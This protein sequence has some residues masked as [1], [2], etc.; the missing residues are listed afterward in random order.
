MVEN[1][2]NQVA[3]AFESCELNNANQEG[4]WENTLTGIS[5]SPLTLSVWTLIY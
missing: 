1:N 5:F 4:Y 2:L 3:D